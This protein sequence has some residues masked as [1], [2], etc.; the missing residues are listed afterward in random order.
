MLDSNKIFWVQDTD[1]SIQTYQQ[2][3]DFVASESSA[4]L[5]Y[6]GKDNS[7]MFANLIKALCNNLD[8]TFVDADFSDTELNTMFSGGYR[9]LV[10]ETSGIKNLN[11]TLLSKLVLESKSRVTLFTSGTTGTPK[12]VTHSITTLV[13]MVKLGEKHASDIWG[14]CYNPTH[15]AGIQVFFQAF[16]NKN[17]MIYIF[18]LDNHQVYNYISEYKITNISA[19]PTFYR[20]FLS[21]NS[22]LPKVKRISVGGEKSDSVLLKRIKNI[23]I[24]AKITN[25]Y[26]STELGSVLASNDEFF[27]ITEANQKFAKI[28]SQRLFVHKSI[29]AVFDSKNDDEWYDTGDIIEWVDVEK[30]TF[31][32]ISRKSEIINT[33]GYKVNPGEIEELLLK[34]DGIN[35]ALVYSKPNAVLGNIIVADI[36]KSENCNLS[37]IE[38]KKI[39]SQSLQSFKV[40][41]IIKF[42]KTIQLTRTGKLRRS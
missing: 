42:V 5:N 40:P 28:V 19:T 35:S 1:N 22:V 11:F 15:M 14:F 29:V 25:I 33:G 8:F 26:A 39:L 41:R 36:S 20:L 18:G 3:I 32:F 9:Q 12:K 13:R 24:N 17:P 23:F 34:I 16:L 27:F 38:I 7:F 37:E 21:I 30:Q 2:L 4:Y 6:R 10:V 31:R